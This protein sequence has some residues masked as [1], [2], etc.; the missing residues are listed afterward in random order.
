[1]G[2]VIKGILCKQLPSGCKI[3]W[4]TKMV[5]FWKQNKAPRMENVWLTDLGEEASTSYTG[6]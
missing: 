4:I 6:E 3:L 2:T 1:M 5:Q